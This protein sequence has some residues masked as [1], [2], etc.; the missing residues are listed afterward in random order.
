MHHISSNNFLAIGE[1]MIEMAPVESGL[2]Q[3]GFAGD[4][5][6]TA[7]HI[8]QILG[9]RASVGFASRLGSD[10]LS[11][12]FMGDLRQDGIDISLIHQDDQR[13]M[14]LYLIELDGVERSFH[15]WRQ[16]S[17]ARVMA[18]DDVW[19]DKISRQSGVIHVSGIT[20]AI[21]S[22]KARQRLLGALSKARDDGAIVSFDPNIRPTL[23]S[24]LEEIQETLCE[25]FSI[26]DIALP[27]FDDEQKHWGDSS[28]I[29]TIERLRSAGIGEII[30]KNGD[31]AV[32]CH[33]GGQTRFIDTPAVSNICDT[34]GAGDA[35]NAG[36]LG[37]RLLGQD[38]IACVNAGQRLSAEILRH[39]G[40]RM[41]KSAVPSL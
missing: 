11:N 30:V 4:C 15:Y 21:L 41:P 35:F 27:S 1:A 8:A 23:W 13:M 37:A 34:T 18:D 6:N 24:S 9:E 38:P 20:L 25:I 22:P 29:A 40:A 2:Y 3:R 10:G 12:Q 16:T 17:A 36:Y 31:Q 19:L 26:T 5:F 33:I 32:A 14:G 7:W 39:F 28:P